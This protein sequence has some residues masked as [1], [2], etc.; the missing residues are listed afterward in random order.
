MKNSKKTLLAFLFVIA[1]LISLFVISSV[2]VSATTTDTNS[3]TATT[4][5]CGDAD[6]DGVVTIKD[7]TLTQMYVAKLSS[8]DYIQLQLADCDD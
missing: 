8:L 1:T 2:S 7:A 3:S 4:Y 6:M 5:I